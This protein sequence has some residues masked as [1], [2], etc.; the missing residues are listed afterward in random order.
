MITYWINVLRGQIRNIETKKVRVGDEVRVEVGVRVGVGF[1][2][3][4]YNF[5]NSY[6][7]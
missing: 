3:G 1:G 5:P 2:V 7:H 6:P 4:I